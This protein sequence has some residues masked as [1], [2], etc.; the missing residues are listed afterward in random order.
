MAI[1][2]IEFKPSS[3][4]ARVQWDP[5]SMDLLVDFVHGGK[6][7]Y[8]SVPENEVNGLSQADSAGK[9]LNANIKPLYAYER[10]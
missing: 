10:R 7:V 3:N 9:Y 5:D 6:G 4:V 8:R 1:R 2:E